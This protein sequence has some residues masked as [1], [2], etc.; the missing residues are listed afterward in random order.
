VL[1]SYAGA[2]GASPVVFFAQQDRLFNTNTV[3]LAYQLRYGKTLPTGLLE[4]PP[5]AR[6]SLVRQLQDPAR[7]QPNLVITGPRAAAGVDFSPLVGVADERAALQRSGFR[8][9]AS[10]D[11]PDGRKMTI[12]WSERRP[13]AS[14]P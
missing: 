7:G 11:L 5:R 9:I 1:N 3:D 8:A 2:R 4:D 13:V 14:G 10:I 12:W 6:E